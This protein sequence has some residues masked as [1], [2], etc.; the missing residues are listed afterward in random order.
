M[1]EEVPMQDM[2]P[3]MRSLALGAMGDFL[4]LIGVVFIL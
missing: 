2:R 3:M 4:L 1:D